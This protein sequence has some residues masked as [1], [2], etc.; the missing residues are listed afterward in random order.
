[1]QDPED[2]VVEMDGPRQWI[3]TAVTFEDDALD[4]VA[5]EEVRGRQT[6]RSATDDQNRN[7]GRNPVGGGD[8]RSAPAQH[9]RELHLSGILDDDVREEGRFVDLVVGPDR[10]DC[11][12]R[13]DILS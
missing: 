10:V 11:A 12:R 6:G 2:L 8:R 3:G 9:D 4:A 13:L 5:G 7:G 1:M